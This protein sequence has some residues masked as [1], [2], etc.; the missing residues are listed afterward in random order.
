MICPIFF[1]NSINFSKSY[2]YDSIVVNYFFFKYSHLNEE[3]IEKK[4]QNYYSDSL[5]NHRKF[6]VYFK[7]YFTPIKLGN[8]SNKMELLD[9]FSFSYNELILKPVDE[10]YKLVSKNLKQPIDNIFDNISSIC[11]LDKKV[12][13]KDDIYYESVFTNVLLNQD[14]MLSELHSS[15]V[16]S[17]DSYK[18][19]SLKQILDNPFIIK[20]LFFNNVNT[21]KDLELLSVSSLLALFSV[22]Y[23]YINRKLFNLKD[24]FSTNLT[25]NIDNVFSDL[26]D[27]SLEIIA[28]RYGFNGEPKTLEEVGKI[29]N[30][31]RERIRQVEKKAEVLIL[32]KARS[33]NSQIISLF[34]HLAKKNGK[35]VTC[36]QMRSFCNDIKLYNRIMYLIQISQS[37]IRYDN[38][39]SILYN[40]EI[41]TPEEF[42]REIIDFFG[43]IVD[44]DYID[45]LEVSEKKVLA[46]HY[47]LYKDTIYLRRGITG[48]DLIADIIDEIFPNGY[49]IAND[50]TYNAL[51]KE[52]KNRF[53]EEFVIP[54]RRA[55][56]A[57]V[58]ERDD[59][60]LIDRGLYKRKYLCAS[61]PTE[62]VN[63]MIEFI[64]ENSPVCSYLTIFEKFKTQLEEMGILNIYNLKGQLDPLLPDDFHTTRSYIQTTPDRVSGNHAI[65]SILKS[66]NGIFSIDD[67]RENF[68]GI[69]D[70]TLYNVIYSE[71]YNNGLLWLSNHRFVYA[72]TLSISENAVKE[73][74]ST[75]DD[76]FVSLNEPTISVRKVYARISLTNQ[77]LLDELKICEDQFALFSLIMAVLPNE[78]GF[79][80]PLISK[81]T[82]SQI[83]TIDVI[84]DYASK[85][86]SFN[87][88]IINL[89]INKMNLKGLYSYLMFME[90]MSENYV[91][92]N[93]DSMIK[94]EKVGL[95]ENTI[96]EIEKLLNLILERFGYIETS[97]FNGYIMLPRISYQWNKYLLIGIVRTY[98]SD[99]FEIENTKN[100]YKDTDFIIRRI[101]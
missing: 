3:D 10:L 61:I 57:R 33:I 86:E 82:S 89:Y 81:D 95:S 75:I 26:N 27:R 59:Y 44:K 94:K 36:E 29:F 49:K 35:Y 34:Y 1:D 28:L 83:R 40:V 22:D 14:N 50:E 90:S 54:S 78:Y 93:V 74:K 18:D 24:D 69:K 70:Y 6:I 19:I 12:N 45:K 21:M 47:R 64:S 32:P 43:N 9:K 51:W 76:L 88:K 92:I 60:C 80:R 62:L 39:L 4:I 84:G 52:F 66:F 72:K 99:K 91:Q 67:I 23:D 11:A 87:S 31:T 58:I 25:E 16:N 100:S 56:D 20:I 13:N 68:K 77:K 73:L 96:S 71:S 85:L 55:I 2:I 41:A 7:R 65:L 37:S 101:R 63:S 98:L 17:K 46:K 97:S 79:K 30:L 5:I 15:I 53:G 38:G 42:S 48:F 8:I